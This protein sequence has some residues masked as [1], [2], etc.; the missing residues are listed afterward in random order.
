MID[1][2]KI[3]EVVPG[4]FA[5]HLPLPMRPTIVNVY[6]VNGGDEWAL[7]DTG[8][9]TPESRSAFLSALDSIGCRPE[10]IRKIVCTHH[11]PDHYG[12]SAAYKELCR[13]EVFLHPLEVEKVGFYLP[14]PRNPKRMDFFAGHGMPVERFASLPPPSEFWKGLYS[15]TRPDHLL[16]D[17]DRI[18]VGERELEVVWTPGHSPG[19]C[20]IFFPKEKV[21]IVGDHLLPKITPHVGINSDVAQDP[22]GDFL[23]SLRKVGELDVETVLPAHGPVYADHRKRVAQLIEFHEYR[24]QVMLDIVRGRPRST[25][26]VALEA[27]SL[28]IE[29]PFMQLFPATFETLAHLEHMRREGRVRRLERGGKAVWAPRDDRGS[30]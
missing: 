24:M 15:P 10:S 23:S 3:R 5:I 8:M 6:L 26:E 28:T 22:L 19:H 4:F 25:Y 27:F 29:S 17:R 21:L 9:P 13:A 12:T 2:A 7:V 30:A 20:V 16:A 11:H 1:T 14:A 18:A